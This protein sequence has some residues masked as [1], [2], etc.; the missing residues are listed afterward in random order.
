MTQVTNNL[1]NGNG[2]GNGRV[3]NGCTYKGFVAYGPRDFDGTGGE[4][5]TQVQVRGR[6]AANAMAYDDFKALLTTEFC[7]RNEIEKLEGE[8]WNHSMVGANHAG[9][10]NRFHELAKLV[11]HLVTPKTKHV[12]GYINGLP[13][14]IRGMLRA[15]QPATIQVAIL[16][17]GILTDEVVRNGTLAKAGEKRKERDL[18]GQVTYHGERQIDDLFDQLQGARYFSKIDL[19]FGY[20]Q[21]RVQD[22]DISKTAFRTRYGHF[23]FTVMPF[24]LTNAPAVFMDLMNRIDV[25]FAKEVEVVCGVLQVRVLVARG[26][27]SWTRGKSRWY[28]RG[29]KRFIKNFSKIAKPLTSLTQKNQKY[30]WGEK[31]EEAFQTLKDNLCNAPILSLPDGV[32]DFVVYCD[33]S[34]QGLGCV[35]MQRDKEWIGCQTKR[36]TIVYH[37]KIVRIPVEEGKVLCVQGERNVGKTKTLMSTKANEPTLSDIPI[38][39]DFEDVFPDDLSGLPPQ[40]Q[41][42]FRIDLI[43]GATPVA[44]SPYR[45]APSE[46]QE[47]SEQLQ[48]LQDKGFIRPSHSPWG[49]PV[50]FVKKKDGSFRMCID[51]RE[52]NKLTIKNRY[53]LPRIDDLFDQLQGARYFSKIDLRSGYHQLRVHDDDIS[54]TAFRTRYGHFEFTV[55]P[56]GLT[57]APAVFMDLMN[58]VCKPYLDKF[59]IVFIDDILIYSKTKEDHENHLRLMLDLLRKEKLYAKFSKCEFWLQEVH[60]LGHV[61]NHDGIHVDPSKIEAVKSWKAP[62]TPSEVRSFLGLAGYYRRFI[63]NFSKIAKPLTS[64]TQKNQKYEWGEKQEEAF[65]TLKDNLCNAP[66]LSLPDGVEDFVIH[67]KNYTT[68]DLELGAVVFALKIWRH[69][70]YGTK[71]V[72]YTD[73]K[74]LQYIFDQK[75]LNMCQRRWLEL[76]SNYECE[77]KYHPGKANVVA[78]ALSRKERVKPQR[79]R[80]MAVTIQSG[81][82]GLIL[83]AQVEAFKDENVIAEG[84]NCTDQQMEKRKDGSLHYMDRIWVALVGGVRTKIMDEAHKTRYSVHPGA[85]KMYYDLRDMHWRPGM[86]KEIAIYVSK[87]L[88]CAKVKAEHQRPSDLLQQPEISKWK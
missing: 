58:R 44:K 22:D 78:D 60:F 76:F 41:V 77:I 30:E 66:I 1:N 83:A 63:E 86:K 19:R 7:P 16:T 54:K 87:C 38:V 42:E 62:T 14:Q 45:L 13:S 33:A 56:F 71:S 12:T 10:T 47:L 43:P 36:L 53:P 88:T 67:E 31:Q 23:E 11:P 8:F 37:E 15:T 4:W 35:L 18:F 40:R 70:L 25:G 3:N 2:N 46:M 81:V 84:L 57:N 85:D 51:Y 79:V 64:L 48:E 49:A 55:M 9:Y 24:G 39:R 68:H 20:N 32:E 26:T 50:L 73:H 6:D 69:Y 74:S 61:V 52:L 72:I 28:S 5:N 75:E 27:F 82:K 29:P 59:V 80:A 21:L 65:Q 17:A 34:N